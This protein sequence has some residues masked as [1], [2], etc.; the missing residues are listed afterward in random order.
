MAAVYR[1]RFVMLEP[2]FDFTLATSM[3]AWRYSEPTIGVQRWSSGKV[4]AGYEV[5]DSGKDIAFGL[6]VLETERVTLAQFL[7]SARAP[8]RAFTFYPDAGGTVNATGY[9]AWLLSPAAGS[10]IMAGLV[11]QTP[12]QFIGALDFEI[13]LR[14]VDNSADWDLRFLPAES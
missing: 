9:L 1:P 14:L 2:S 13:T 11:R 4:P 10:D 3:R 8:M 7:R 5:G 12:P 6:R